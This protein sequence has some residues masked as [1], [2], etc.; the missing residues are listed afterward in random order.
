MLWVPPAPALTKFTPGHDARI[1]VTDDSSNP[2]RIDVQ[3]KFSDL[4][5]C[6]CSLASM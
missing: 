3:I 1:E 6:P 5:D 4:M 2:N